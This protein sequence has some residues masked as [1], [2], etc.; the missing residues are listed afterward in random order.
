MNGHSLYEMNE[1]SVYKTNEDLANFKP[2]NK[3]ER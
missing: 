1:H 3:G 2:V